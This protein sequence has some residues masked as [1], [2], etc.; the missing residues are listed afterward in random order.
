MT[1]P[2]SDAAPGISRL[3]SA[4]Q[5]GDSL[6]PTGSFSFSN[7]L[8]SA[9]QEHVVHDRRTLAEFVL[10]RGP[11]LGDRRRD[12]LA[13]GTSRRADAR[14]P[15][16][17]MPLIMQPSTARSSEEARIMTTRMGRKL[18]ELGDVRSLPPRRCIGGSQI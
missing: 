4:L 5:F 2:D 13:G 7:G 9:V 11:A 8:E 6:L 17:S 18:A 3:M 12:R 14:T 10:H 1:S 16:G 15:A